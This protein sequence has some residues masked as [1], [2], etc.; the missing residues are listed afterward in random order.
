[1]SAQVFF[2]FHYKNLLMS[3]G[4]ITSTC[5]AFCY[6]LITSGFNL[7]LMLKIHQSPI[8][9]EWFWAMFNLGGD[10]FVVLLILLL[11]ERKTGEITSWVFKTWCIGGVLVHL[12][13]HSFPTPRPGLVIGVEHLSLIDH[14]ALLSGSMPSGHALAAFCCGLIVS[15]QIISKGGSRL[16]LL[17]VAVL[18]SLSAWARVAVGAHWPVDVIAALGL[19]IF[20][21]ASACY[22]EKKYCWNAWF[23]TKTGIVFL[24]VIHLILSIYFISLKTNF[25]I[26]QLLLACFTLASFHR[27]YFLVTSCFVSTYKSA[28]VKR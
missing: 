6:G 28:E 5:V 7:S 2:R 26:V 12:I 1:M 8:M 11:A 23:Q 13:K 20:V 21:L 27:V 14:P 9:P 25:F 19:A 18:V 10:A 17:A 4:L 22:W 3:L 24:I 16:W 15:T